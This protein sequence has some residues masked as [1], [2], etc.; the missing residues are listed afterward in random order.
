M[1]GKSDVYIGFL[2][3]YF[4]SIQDKFNKINAQKGFNL[5]TF[6]C[7]NSN[8]IL[9][10]VNIHLY[11]FNPKYCEKESIKLS[12]KGIL[13]YAKVDSYNILN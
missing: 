1:T 6:I 5:V 4:P 12:N 7:L 9:S 11:L 3:L 2:G 13:V 10:L 8:T